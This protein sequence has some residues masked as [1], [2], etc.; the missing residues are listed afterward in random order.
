MRNEGTELQVMK[1]LVISADNEL[2]ETPE[3]RKIKNRRVKG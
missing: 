3:R 2:G 1:I